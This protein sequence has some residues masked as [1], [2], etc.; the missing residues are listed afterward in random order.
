MSDLPVAQDSIVGIL[1]YKMDIREGIM[2]KTLFTSFLAVILI[3]GFCSIAKAIDDKSLIL[4]F[5]FDSEKGGTVQDMTGNGH[6]GTLSNAD[7]IKKPVKIG[8][9]ALQIEDQ[10]ASMTVESFKELDEY[11]DNTFV[12]WFYLTAGSNGAWSQIIAKKAPGSDRSPG[13]WINPGGTGIHYRYNAGNQ[14]FSRIGPGGEGSDFPLDEWFHLAGVKK[15][16]NLKMYIDGEEKGSVG[17]PAKHDQGKEKLYIGL[18]G[19][20]SATFIIDDLGVYNRALTEKEVNEDM[21]K[22]VLPQAVRI[23]GKLTTTWASIKNSL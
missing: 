11:Q 13:I 2:M 12:W 9:G 5:S 18:T 14:G 17:V 15:G 4:Y 1:G 7:I 22:G 16:A 21:E 20:R 23:E 19:Y 10:N 3:V 6:D 8:N